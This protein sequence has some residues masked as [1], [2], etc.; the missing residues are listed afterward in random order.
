[1]QFSRCRPKKNHTLLYLFLSHFGYSQFSNEFI[2]LCSSVKIHFWH[3]QPLTIRLSSIAFRCKLYAHFLYYVLLTMYIRFC[4]NRADF[5]FPSR[6][7]CRRPQIFSFEVRRFVFLHSQLSKA[8]PS[9]WRID[10]SR[11]VGRGQ[12]QQCLN[13]FS[14]IREW[15]YPTDRNIVDGNCAQRRENAEVVSVVCFHLKASTH[16]VINLNTR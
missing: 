10:W 11:N 4:G 12:L 13:E 6:S 15:L 9:N 5:L 7:P 16:V 1:M 3:R 2:P 8:P 14:L